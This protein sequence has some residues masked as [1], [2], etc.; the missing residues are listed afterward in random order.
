MRIPPRTVSFADNPSF[1]NRG[2]ARNRA[3]PQQISAVIQQAPQQQLSLFQQK[4]AEI[5][6]QGRTE[7][8]QFKLAAQQIVRRD[9]P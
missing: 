8:M 5:K 9:C 7:G 4:R 3:L 1:I 2:L 6:A